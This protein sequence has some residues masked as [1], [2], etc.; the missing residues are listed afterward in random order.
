MGEW[1][2]SSKIENFNFYDGCEGEFISPRYSFLLLK[3]AGLLWK[4]ISIIVM[5]RLVITTLKYF[6]CCVVPTVMTHFKWWVS[7]IKDVCFFLSW[8]TPS[9]DIIS[10]LTKQICL[11]PKIILHIKKIS[12]LGNNLTHPVLVHTQYK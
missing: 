5:W 7:G 9:D 10:I 1:N 2:Q 6:G 12:F 11:I 3:L 4:F 8:N